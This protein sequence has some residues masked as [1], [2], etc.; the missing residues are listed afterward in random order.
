MSTK[1]I[2][3]CGII[4]FVL[5]F[6]L[7]QIATAQF[8]QSAFTE[9]SVARLGLSGLGMNFASA[10]PAILSNLPVNQRFILTLEAD[11][12]NFETTFKDDLPDL[13]IQ[14]AITSRLIFALAQSKRAVPSQANANRGHR[15]DPFLQHPLRF[16]VFGHQQD[17]SAGIGVQLQADL[18]LGLAVRHENYTVVPPA[19]GPV[20]FGQSFRTFDLGLRKSVPRLNAGLVLRNLIKNRTTKPFTQ[21]LRFV[22]LTDP[23]QSFD[24]NP[25]QF[26]G[27][28]FEPKFALE[29]GVLWTAGS[30]WELLGDMSSRGEYALGLRWRVFSKFSV[31]S[32]N[33]RRFDRVYS[34]ATV[35]YTALGGQFQ[36]DK[37]A[38][39]LTWII[40]R[41]AGRNQ[42]VSMPYGTYDLTQVTNNRLL[43]AGSFSL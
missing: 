39:G 5:V 22:N 18:C 15:D 33:G 6:V 4:I 11:H 10:N 21:P 23:T 13:S 19:L 38:L 14:V 40:P 9:A 32:G 12:N 25:L 41:R 7:P 16:L 34:D 36:N 26:N 29:G 30:H 20:A 17:W 43:I 2:Q 42:I 1:L 3:R 31:T 24:W 8:V 27:V 28:A 35:T 37:F